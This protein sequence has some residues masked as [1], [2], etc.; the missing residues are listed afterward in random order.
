[1]ICSDDVWA[2]AGETGIGCAQ[3][4][5]RLPA[6]TL[7][8]RPEARTYCLVSARKPSSRGRS[9]SIGLPT[10]FIFSLERERTRELLSAKQGGHGDRRSVAN[11]GQD[12]IA[13]GDRRSVV[14]YS[15]MALAY[16]AP[17]LT[18]PPPPIAGACSAAALT[19]RLSP[20][21]V[22]SACTKARL[23]GTL[24]LQRAS[25][26]PCFHLGARASPRAL[27]CKTGVS[28][29][30]LV[31]HSDMSAG[32]SAEAVL[33]G[34]LALQPNRLQ[35]HARLGASV[36]QRFRLKSFRSSRA[37]KPSAAE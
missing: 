6:T 16:L 33:A 4:H 36:L 27:V 10:R 29:Q 3:L 34:M 25:D 8:W 18:S 20:L 19:I 37:T 5:L 22:V 24:A 28:V 30:A 26:E 21:P 11:G 12:P 14:P 32:L 13:N 7:I 23:A 15:R 1:M 31:T 35:Q 17:C 9:R 2:G